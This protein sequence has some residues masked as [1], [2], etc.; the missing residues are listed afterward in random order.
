M[1]MH[2]QQ[3][4]DENIKRLVCGPLNDNCVRMYLIHYTGNFLFNN[5]TQA[6]QIIKD[7]TPEVEAFKLRLQVT[8]SDIEQWLHAEQK[9]L[10]DLK[11]EPQERVLASAYV[12]ALIQRRQVE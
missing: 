5:Y 9:F 8:D 1:D 6:V 7:Y 4:D 3:W 10:E 11:E 12:E 2:Y